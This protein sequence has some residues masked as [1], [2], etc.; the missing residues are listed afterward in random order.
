MTLLLQVEPV[1]QEV[2]VTTGTLLAKAR[3]LDLAN[4]EQMNFAIKVG[5]ELLIQ[6]LKIQLDVVAAILTHHHHH[7][8]THLLL[9]G[10]SAD[11]TLLPVLS[12]QVVVLVATVGFAKMV[13]QVN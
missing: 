3:I 2:L 6:D 11:R 12:M 10:G 5:E 1:V 9:P 13:K 7:Q 8:E 4:K